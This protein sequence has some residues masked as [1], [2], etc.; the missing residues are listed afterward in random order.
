M[1]ECMLKPDRLSAGEELFRIGRIAP[2]VEAVGQPKLEVEQTVFRC[3]SN[4]DG[5][6]SR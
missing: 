5:L 3:G 6:R 4:R 2:S 1:K